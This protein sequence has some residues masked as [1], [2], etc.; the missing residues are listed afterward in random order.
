MPIHVLLS[1]T[2]FS[3]VAGITPGP[4]NI[5]SLAT[6]CQFGKKI[7]LKQ[8]IGIFIGFCTDYILGA[9][10]VFFIGLA[11]N[12]YVSMFSFVG[13][14]YLI[15]LAFKMLKSSFSAEEKKVSKPNF[16][17]GFLVQLTNVK[18]I[19]T[20]VTGL[21]T[22]VLPHTSNFLLLILYGLPILLGPICNLVWLLAGLALQRFF[23]KYQKSLNI[24]FAIL[25]F[26]CAISLCSVYFVGK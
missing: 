9:V 6:S 2:I 16:F 4:A 19:L 7:A 20:C 22:Y 3:T 17:T 12:K 8:W 24:I 21:S 1:L 14:I 23:S 13:A 26:A 18:V 10:A 11:L 5:T 15:Y 25:I